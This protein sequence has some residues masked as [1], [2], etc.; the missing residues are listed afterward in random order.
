MH[1]RCFQHRPIKSDQKQFSK[2]NLAGWLTLATAR[3]TVRN[4]Q[5]FLNTNLFW[6]KDQAQYKQIVAGRKQHSG[7]G[8]QSGS[9]ATKK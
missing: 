4:N 5:T 7:T 3:A 9:C 6:R 1:T 8:D 2:I